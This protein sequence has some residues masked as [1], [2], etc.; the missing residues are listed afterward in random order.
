MN[1]VR[2]DPGCYTVNPGEMYSRPGPSTDFDF[3]RRGSSVHLKLIGSWLVSVWCVV[4]M[5]TA[6]SAQSN[7]PVGQWEVKVT[8][9]IQSQ[10]ITGTAFVEF[11]GDQTLSGYV[12]V[13]R[14]TYLANVSGQWM[15]A[16]SRIVGEFLA[17]GT[18]Y[19]FVG[20]ARAGKSIS[21]RG[22]RWDG[23]KLSMSGRPLAALPDRSGWYVGTMRQYGQT[24]TL[25]IM[26]T[27]ADGGGSPGLYEMS[28]TLTF[29]G[30]TF[31]LSG[32]AVVNRSG[33]FIVTIDNL[34]NGR[35]ASIW[36]TLPRNRAVSASGV[37]LGDRSSIKVRLTKA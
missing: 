7:S 23:G 35:E 20:T 11:H 22:T 2:S 5:T 18:A 30:Q 1:N 36:G 4:G 16:G 21:L 28:G 8:G 29:G 37:D 33:G 32:V 31:V 27:P 24:G 15:W 26:F 10:S 3:N 25:A 9:K 6:A 34:S 14:G 12:L 17:D 19:E 13:R